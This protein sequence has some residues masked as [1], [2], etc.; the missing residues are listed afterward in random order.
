MDK[1]VST[2]YEPPSPLYRPLAMRPPFVRICYPNGLNISICN[3][4]L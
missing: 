4:T 3:A 2:I 1:G